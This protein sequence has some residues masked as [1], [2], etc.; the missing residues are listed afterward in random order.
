MGRPLNSKYFNPVPT[1]N[2]EGVDSITITNAGSYTAQPT[3]SISAPN[4]PNG[5]SATLGTV[6]M[7][8]LS[9]TVVTSGTGDVSA[10]YVPGNILTVVG[11]TGT[12]STF[13]VASVKVRTAANQ[14][15]AGGFDN[16]DTVTFSTGWSTP[17]VLT[18]TVDG[19]GAITGVTITNAGVRSTTP[20]PADPVQP[21]S[22][23]GEGTLSGTTFNLGFGVNAVT[24]NA[25]GDY[26]VISA[27][28]RTTTTNSANGTGA[29]L[30]VTYGVLSV[31]VTNAGDGYVNAADAAVTFSAGA[32]EATAVLTATGTNVI[33]AHAFVVDGTQTLD[34]DII[35]QT[36]TNEYLMETTEGQSICTLVA[37]DSLS[38]GQAYIKATDALNSTYY[39]TKLTAHLAVLEQWTADEGGFVHSGGTDT[40]WTLESTSIDPTGET[41]QI[42][43]V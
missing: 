21:D 25:I 1:S 27:N 22:R 10:D 4:L 28:P 18:L 7:K 12:A 17:A 41:V 30:T 26:T 38:E 15:D 37:S 9:A 23:T 2:G 32:A 20:L 5:T 31:P 19:G 35:K 6:H 14:A 33:L 36:S 40:P 16:G 11:G 42:E 39:V 24:V 29:T 43:S 13:T 8:A 3:V 34:A